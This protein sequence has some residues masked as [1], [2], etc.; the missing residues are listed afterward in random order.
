M[1]QHRS[2]GGFPAPPACSGRLLEATAIKTLCA[3]L[4]LSLFLATLP[5]CE[6][7]EGPLERASRGINKAIDG[8]MEKAVTLPDAPAAS[9]IAIRH[10][11]V[12]RV[13]ASGAGKN[14]MNRP[15]DRP[16]PPPAEEFLPPTQAESKEPNSQADSQ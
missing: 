3:T 15:P 9:P 13:L 6:N 16:I 14:G 2:E 1:Q 5:A 11:H 4:F 12:K 7:A 10:F 8:R